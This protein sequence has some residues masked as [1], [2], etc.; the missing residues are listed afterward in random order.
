M[1]IIDAQCVSCGK[2]WWQLPNHTM[3]GFR[4]VQC[5]ECLAWYTLPLS[6]RARV[7]YACALPLV[8]LAALSTAIEGVAF[9]PGLFTAVIVGTLVKDAVMR[10]KP[11]TPHTTEGGRAS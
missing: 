2:E 3:L 8:G 1:P 10:R 9:A 7:V 6:T 4:R 5:P 11:A